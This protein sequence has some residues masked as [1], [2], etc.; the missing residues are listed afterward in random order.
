M[1]NKKHMKVG[2]QTKKVMPFLDS[3]EITLDHQHSK[4]FQAKKN[5]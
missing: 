5:C 1:K 3:N 4:L 2:K